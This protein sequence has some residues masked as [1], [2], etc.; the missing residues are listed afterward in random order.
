MAAEKFEHLHT[1][2]GRYGKDFFQ[3]IARGTQLVQVST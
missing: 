1:S 3:R 2:D